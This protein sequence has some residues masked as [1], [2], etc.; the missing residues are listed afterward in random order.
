MRY[1]QYPGLRCARCDGNDGGTSTGQATPAPPTGKD[2]SECLFD[3]SNS[4]FT[5]GFVLI[6]TIAGVKMKSYKPLAV[7][8]LF[9]SFGDATYGYFYNCADMIKDYE[10]SIKKAKTSV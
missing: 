9:G 4:W 8:A 7:A 10:S 2:V 5:T 6:G 1:P 3:I